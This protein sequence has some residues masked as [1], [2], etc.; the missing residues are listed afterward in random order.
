MVVYVGP[1]GYHDP[2]R[3]FPVRFDPGHAC[4]CAEHPRQPGPQLNAVL[5][6]GDFTVKAYR[7][8]FVKV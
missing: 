1:S 5:W 6:F 7:A 4:A 3:V 8:Q 2:S